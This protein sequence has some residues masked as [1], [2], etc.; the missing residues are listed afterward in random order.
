[1]LGGL[2][3]FLLRMGDFREALE[4]IERG[5]SVARRTGDPVAIQTAGSMLGLSLE[6]TG[7]I[8]S[9]EKRRAVALVGSGE[10]QRIRTVRMGFD[11]RVNAL[12][13]QAR[14]HWLRGRCDQAATVASD[15]IKQAELLDHQCT[16]GSG[17]GKDRR[18]VS[19]KRRRGWHEAFV[20][21][22][23][24]TLTARPAPRR[25]PRQPR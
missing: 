3:A 7:D 14:C 1:M 25:T 18:R 4:V 24:E 17:H 22:C 2:G 12:C 10:A 19:G 9:A 21:A 6:L 15:A 13:G 16:S 5:E 23:P 11:P 8:V 20:P